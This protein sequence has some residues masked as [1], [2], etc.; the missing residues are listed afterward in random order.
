MKMLNVADEDELEFSAILAFLSES[1][2]ATD[3]PRT[4]ANFTRISLHDSP[5]P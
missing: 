2:C 3:Q 1:D 5:P 4:F